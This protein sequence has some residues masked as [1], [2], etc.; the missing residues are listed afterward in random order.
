M[1]SYIKHSARQLFTRP[2]AWSYDVDEDLEDENDED[3]IKVYRGTQNP[4][5]AWEEIKVTQNQKDT[6]LLHVDTP[7]YEDKSGEHKLHFI[8]S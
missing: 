5:Q 3:K 7:V 8:S 1:F 2:G 4:T 6:Q